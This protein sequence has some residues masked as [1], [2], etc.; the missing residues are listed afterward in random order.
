MGLYA[1]LR[2]EAAREGAKILFVDEAHFRADVDLRY[3]WV[4]R[5]EEAL[6]DSSSPKRGEK[7]SYYSAVCVESGEVIAMPLEEN[8]NCET[9]VSFLK[10]LRASFVE[11]LIVIWDNGPAHRGP[12]MREYLTTPGLKIRLVALPGY[13]PDFNS[14]EAIW[15]WIREDVTANICFGT[16]AK[17]RAAIDRFFAEVIERTSE[18]TKRCRRQLQAQADALLAAANQ[19]S[20]DTLHADLTVRLV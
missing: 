15:E 1:D 18:V 12:A 14:D 17:V 11:P 5:G 13:S 3:K 16:A 4:L 7:A 20:N 8:S 6:V 10:Q 9:S 19:L 2:C